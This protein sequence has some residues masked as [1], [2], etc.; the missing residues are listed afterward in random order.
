MSKAS[1]RRINSSNRNGGQYVTH[2][3]E[4]FEKRLKN[5][6]RHSRFYYIYHTDY[7]KSTYNGSGNSHDRR[8]ESYKSKKRRKLF[9]TRNIMCIRIKQFNYDDPTNWGVM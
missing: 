7:I 1:Q 3:Q 2:T 4:R 5:Y 8:K 9:L 6:Q